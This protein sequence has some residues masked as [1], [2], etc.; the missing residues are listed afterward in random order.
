[1]VQAGLE[2]FAEQKAKLEKRHGM[3]FELVAVVDSQ[4]YWF[5]D[6]GIDAAKVSSHFDEESVNYH[7]GIAG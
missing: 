4:T 6:K 5:D 2:L 3:N 7:E 1:M